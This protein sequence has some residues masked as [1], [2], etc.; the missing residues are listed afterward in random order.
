MTV[1]VAG[2][3]NWGKNIVRTLH[4][5]QALHSVAEA[6]DLLREGLAAT[7]PDVKLF[8]HFD[9]V[10]ASDC[11]AVAIATPAPTHFALAKSALVAGKDVF[12]EKPMTLSSHD[13]EELCRLAEERGRIL[14]VGHLLLYQPAIRA[15]AEVV[16]DG[17]IGDLTSIHQERLNLGKARSVE[18]VLWSLGVHDV[19]VAMY[20]V[21]MGATETIGIGQSV[22]TAGVEDDYYLHCTYAN[23]VQSHLHCSWLW[24]ER[25]RKM[26]VVGSKA[27]LVYD[28]LAQKVML[29][30]KSI[31]ADLNNQDGGSTLLFEGAGEPLLLEMEH[32][33]HCCSTREAPI[34]DG[35]SGLEVVRALER[36]AR[37]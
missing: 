20:L 31:D 4:G 35:R 24:P 26:V 32:F 7:Y 2:A 15:I 9:D 16:R 3:G 13:A 33:L 29:H 28:E 27:M 37:A 14:M 21:G 34:S 12:V 8:E 1:A 6:S 18:N 10:L 5:V 22:L 19:A 23:G 25:S 11:T 30:E 17:G 36:A